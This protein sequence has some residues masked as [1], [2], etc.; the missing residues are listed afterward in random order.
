MV[1]QVVTTQTR[2]AQTGSTD[3]SDRYHLCPQPPHLLLSRHLLRVSPM[4]DTHSH[5]AHSG[6]HPPQLFAPFSCWYFLCVLIFVSPGPSAQQL[7][8]FTVLEWSEISCPTPDRKR[9][10]PIRGDD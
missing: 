7:S 5:V 8:V 3:R 9:I 1:M 6:S 4:E 10:D 2:G